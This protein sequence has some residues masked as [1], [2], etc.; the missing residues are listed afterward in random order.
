[1]ARVSR[2]EIDKELDMIEAIP[3]ACDDS[4]SPTRAARMSRS[5]GRKSDRPAE[6]TTY[7]SGG[8]T[9]VQPAGSEQ[10]R[11]LASRQI[12][13]CSPRLWRDASN[14]TC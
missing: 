10:I 2:S 14:S 11:P 9:L 5:A 3:Q 12:T 13:R 7:G 8:A 6:S 4:S 1:M